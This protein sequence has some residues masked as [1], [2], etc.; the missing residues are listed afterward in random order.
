LRGVEQDGRYWDVPLEPG[1]RVL[2][3]AACRTVREMMV[4]GATEGTGREL[5]ANLMRL[6]GREDVF[7]ATK[8]GTAEK[9]PGETCLHVELRERARWER[10]GLRPTRERLASL[11]GMKKPH[12][13]CYTSSMC[14]LVRDPDTG[15]EL[16]AL[17]V[18][19]E[20]RGKERFGSRVAGPAA[21]AILAEALRYTRNGRVAEPELVEGFG[22]ATTALANERLHPWQEDER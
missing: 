18:V 4:L 9:V 13:A 12:R 15:R 17:V 2:S 7:V 6:M 3:E 20:P 1:Q 14:A 11:K 8:T 19:D 22:R 5:R 16:M 10:E 21:G